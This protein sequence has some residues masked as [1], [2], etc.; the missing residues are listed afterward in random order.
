MKTVEGSVWTTLRPEMV[1]SLVD[2]ICQPAVVTHTESSEEKLS[3][4][5][6]VNQNT[7]DEDRN[8][9]LNFLV[10]NQRTMLTKDHRMPAMNKTL[11]VVLSILYVRHSVQEVHNRDLMLWLY[12][13]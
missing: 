3:F 7:E 6:L 5:V 13:R 2:I 8:R 9:R 10:S 4:L 1:A 11:N 12:T